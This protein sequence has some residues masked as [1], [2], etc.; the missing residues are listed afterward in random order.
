L[1]WVAILAAFSVC[2]ARAV[3]PLTVPPATTSVAVLIFAMAATTSLILVLRRDGWIRREAAGSGLPQSAVAAAS[4]SETVQRRTWRPALI[5]LGRFVFIAAAVIGIA[6]AAAGYSRFAYYLLSNLQITLIGCLGLMLL[7]AMVR[8]AIERLPMLALSPRRRAAAAQLSETEPPGDR[9]WLNLA[10]DPLLIGFGIFLL[11]PVWQVPRDELMLWLQSLA[12]GVT[13]GGITISPMDA[14]LS[15]ITLA[16]ALTAVRAISN[17]LAERILP[18][19]RLDPGLR[20]SIAVGFGHVGVI[21]AALLAIAVLGI[22]LSHLALVAGALSVGIGF[23][24]QNVV[25]NFVSGL[26]LLAERPVKVG[27][28]VMIGDKKGF[29]RRINVRSTELETFERSTIIVPNSDLL[30]QAV[31]NWTHKDTIGR[32]DVQVGVDYGSDLDGVRKVLLACA[33][34]HPDVTRQ[35]AP[36]VLFR[37]FGDSA[38][39]IELR[40]FLFDVSKQLRVASDLRFAIDRAFRDAGIAI[41][42]PR[43]EVWMTHVSEPA[44]PPAP[45]HG[46]PAIVEESARRSAGE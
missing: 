16:V 19:T 23:G 37:E 6:T 39:V 30:S 36:F 45:E 40:A 34:A 25:S 24:L 10:L 32:V 31:T 21:L 20:H 18:R 28:Y 41:P 38:L 4:E 7:R 11:A 5:E 8:E 14:L 1:I 44:E 22:N 15:L 17:A 46:L 2:A 9:F 35:P 13:L 33:E 12:R 26:I 42:Y 29:V 43:R 27:D 3:A